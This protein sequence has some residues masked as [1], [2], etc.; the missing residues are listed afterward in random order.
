MKS[1]S[2]KSQKGN[3]I[4]LEARLARWLRSRICFDALLVVTLAF[5]AID[6][7]G[8]QPSASDSRA[9][10][11]AAYVEGELLVKLAGGEAKPQVATSPHNAVGA[12]VLR[13][14][15]AIGWEHVRLPEGM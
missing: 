2:M 12:T 3:R 11:G 6:A 13:R 7:S 5:H 14:F 15:P 1:T 10:R 8:Q 4:L 9:A